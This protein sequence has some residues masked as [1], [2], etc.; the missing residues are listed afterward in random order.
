MLAIRLNL[1]KYQTTNIRVLAWLWRSF[2][3]VM[4]WPAMLRVIVSGAW[5]WEAP[6]SREGACPGYAGGGGRSQICVAP[7]PLPDNSLPIRGDELV[8][9]PED[10]PV[11]KPEDKPEDTP[12]DKPEDTPEDKPDEACVRAVKSFVLAMC[13]KTPAAPA[14]P[15]AP[16]I[17][18]TPATSCSSTSLPPLL[19]R[20]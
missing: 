19:D 18:A 13:F 5:L 6:W 9:L 7:A 17:S 1:P 11:D 3:G 20:L 10:T 14:A 15:A 12:E 16:A 4:I 8:S 2:V